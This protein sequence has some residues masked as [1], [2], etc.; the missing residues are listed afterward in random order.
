M[1]SRSII[2]AILYAN[3]LLF[4]LFVIPLTHHWVD[5][6]FLALRSIDI[7]DFAGRVLQVWL[8]GSTIIASGLFGLIVWQN[9]RA[10][11]TARPL[12]FEGILLLT[13]WIIVI[14]ACVFGFVLGMG[15]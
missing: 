5:R 4:A 13:W 15:G 10:T 1:C 9:R 8:V 3:F 12:K 14:G 6:G 2:R 11:L 7:E